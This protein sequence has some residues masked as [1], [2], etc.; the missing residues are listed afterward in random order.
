MSQLLNTV[1]GKQVIATDN[2]TNG[3]ISRQALIWMICEYYDHSLT[4]DQMQE[5]CDRYPCGEDERGAFAEGAD[6]AIQLVRHTEENRRRNS[7]LL[8]DTMA[9]IQFRDHTY[10]Q[11]KMG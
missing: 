10:E 9:N 6:V 7:E 5:R 1:L 11:D 3:S 4:A 8:A 2:A